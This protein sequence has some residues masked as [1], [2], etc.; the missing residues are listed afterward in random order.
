[1]DLFEFVRAMI[2]KKILKIEETRTKLAYLRHPDSEANA[3]DWTN[4]E[5]WKPKTQ[6]STG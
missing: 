6:R 4:A 1:M 3:D 2:R 5:E